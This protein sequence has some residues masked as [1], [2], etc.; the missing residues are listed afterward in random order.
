MSVVFHAP[1]GHV[2]TVKLPRF[3]VASIFLRLCCDAF[4]IRSCLSL[5]LCSNS[6]CTFFLPVIY[7]AVRLSVLINASYGPLYKIRPPKSPAPG[8]TSTIQSEFFINSS[9]CSTTTI[10]FHMSLSHFI[11]PMTLFISHSSRPIVGS[12]RTYM[13]HVSL[14]PSC[15]ASLNLCI[16]HH[17]SVSI[18][19]SV[20]M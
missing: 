18:C 11:A 19:L 12:S 13:I 3:I 7:C 9:L 15:F 16:S 8:H 2:I 1:D 4:F 10:V 6:T 17:E 5:G 20:L 14:L